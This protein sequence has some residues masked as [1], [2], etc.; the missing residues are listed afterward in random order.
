[1]IKDLKE[2][3]YSNIG[4]TILVVTHGG[5]LNYLLCT[6]TNNVPNSSSEFFI[7]ENN[8]ISIMEFKERYDEFKQKN[9]VDAYLV[10]YNLQLNEK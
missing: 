6:Y 10:A 7:P 2:M 4:K 3:Y 5:F 9:F 1:V 8:S